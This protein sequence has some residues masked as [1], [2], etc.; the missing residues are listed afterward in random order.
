MSEMINKFTGAQR[1]VLTMLYNQDTADYYDIL[2]A[3]GNSATIKKL[4]EANLV[5]L[6]DTPESS[7]EWKITFA[8]RFA[9]ENDFDLKNM[10]KAAYLRLIGKINEGFDF[11]DAAYHVSTKYAVD[12]EKI[13]KMYDENFLATKRAKLR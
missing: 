13:E 5:S 3:G 2:R 7:K 9:T 1:A 11:P 4:V 12:Q 10:L 8:G 6:C